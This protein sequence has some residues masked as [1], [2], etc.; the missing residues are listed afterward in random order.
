[1][2]RL[3]EEQYRL[4]SKGYDFEVVVKNNNMAEFIRL[5]FDRYEH[6]IHSFYFEREFKGILDID[7]FGSEFPKDKGYKIYREKAAEVL[8]IKL[9]HLNRCA[10][11]A[12]KEFL[13]IDNLSLVQENV[14]AQKDYAEAYRL[15]K[16]GIV[17]P[18]AYLDKMYLSKYARHFYSEAELEAFRAKWSK[19]GGA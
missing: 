2:E 19:Q 7:L 6:E 5:F 11:V 12:F 9:E 13:N 4:R 17:F 14:G 10:A 1:V 8:L 3:A 16:D 15:F 18:E